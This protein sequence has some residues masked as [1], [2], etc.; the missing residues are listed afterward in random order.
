MLRKMMELS[1]QNLFF[2]SP[3]SITMALCLVRVTR[4]DPAVRHATHLV[5]SALA[6]RISLAVLVHVVKLVIMVFQIVEVSNVSQS[7]FDNFI[8]SFTSHVIAH[9]TNAIENLHKA[10]FSI[11]G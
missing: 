1:A 3:H 4:E 7:S 9:V 10:S 5:D 6:S 11:L 8:N 2:L